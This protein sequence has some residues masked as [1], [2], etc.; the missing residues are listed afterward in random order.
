MLGNRGP[1]RR[2]LSYVIPT[3]AEGG[4]E[5]RATAKT[6]HE[7]PHYVRS[8]MASPFSA[9]VVLAA[10]SMNDEA[11]ANEYSVSSIS[12]IGHAVRGWRSSE[13]P[14]PAGRG[15]QGLFKPLWCALLMLMV[16]LLFGGIA[17]AQGPDQELPYDEK[18][19][20]S[21]DKTLMC[22]VCPAETIDQAQVEL[23]RQMRRIV[24]EML[25]QGAD[26]D[27]ILDFFVDRYGPQVLAA[28]PKSGV[29]LLAWILPAV[30]VLVALAAVFAIIRS[31]A[32]HG[33]RGMTTES[34]LEDDLDPYLEAIDREL[35]LSEDSNIG[36]G[37]SPFGPEPPQSNEGRLGAITPGPRD[38]EP[39]KKDG[40]KRDG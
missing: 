8:D 3:P 1:N 5:S 30:G 4:E 40:P 37:Q 24:R 29:N 20:Q 21:I 9:A 39:P 17:Q 28:P 18:E 23:S 26:R 14:G 10:T 11:S 34:A 33:G 15:W 36:T 25:A 2:W 31:M 12:G 7:T 22:P 32:S 27:E 13:T 38:V 6:M 16:L 19:A 35:A